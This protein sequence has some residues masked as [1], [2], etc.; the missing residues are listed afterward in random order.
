VTMLAI[1]FVMLLTINA[2]QGWNRR[3]HGSH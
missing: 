2:L 1:S 3:R